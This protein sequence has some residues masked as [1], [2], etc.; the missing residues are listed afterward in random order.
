MEINMNIFPLI[1]DELKVI[2]EEE[3]E[4]ISIVYDLSEVKSVKLDM[5]NA[6][7]DKAGM[8]YLSDKVAGYMINPTA[9]YEGKTLTAYSRQ[10]E[11][12]SK[13]K[14]LLKNKIF[15]YQVI[16]YSSS[17]VYNTLDEKTFKLKELDKPIIRN[18]SYWIIRYAEM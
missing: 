10:V 8:E 3:P 16:F 1:Y 7:F 5:P 17:P 2:E 14:E 18:D 15:L 4:T 11:D 9:L 13:L 6:R 12:I